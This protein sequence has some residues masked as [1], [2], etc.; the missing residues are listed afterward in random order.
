MILKTR[1]EGAT[2]MNAKLVAASLILLGASVSGGNASA[3]CVCR[4]VDGEV[5]AIC[6]SSIDLPPICAPRICPLTPPSL[7]PLPRP[8]LPPIGTKTCRQEQVY[9]EYTKRYEWKTIC[10]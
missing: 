7:E 3:A 2:T 9:N 5:K 1:R 6:S 4:C 8:T 10:R